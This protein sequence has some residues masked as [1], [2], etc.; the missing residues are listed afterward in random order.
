VSSLHYV[1]TDTGKIEGRS[2]DSREEGWYQSPASAHIISNYKYSPLG[3]ENIVIGSQ[4]WERRDSGW[5]ASTTDI[6]CYDALVRI[7]SILAYGGNHDDSV[8][9]VDGPTMGGEPT[10]RLY[11]STSKDAGRLL[12]SI[13]ERSLGDSPSEREALASTKEIFSD[14]TGTTEVLV[15]KN[16]GRV[17]SLVL[18]RDGPKLSDRSEIVVDQYGEPVDIK[19]P[20]NVPPPTEDQRSGSSCPEP[21]GDFPWIPAAIAAVVAPLLFLAGSSFL[22]PR[23]L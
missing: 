1:E 21:P 17:Y 20:P 10:T 3:L 5:S 2:L 14:L 16:T 12:I 23:R 7:K 6:A 22:W 19:P 8:D 13:S 9:E 15:G 4:V 11:K 18:T